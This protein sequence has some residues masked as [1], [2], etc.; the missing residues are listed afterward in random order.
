MPARPGGATWQ[1]LKAAGWY[2]LFALIWIFATDRLLGIVAADQA[3]YADFQTYKGVAF[4]VVTALLMFLLVRGPLAKAMEAGN[5]ARMAAEAMRYSEARFRGIYERALA[6]ILIVS[7]DGRIERCNPAA[8][9]MLGY[10]E[11]ELKGRHFTDIIHPEDR[12]SD[13]DKGR[14]LRAGELTSFEVES[15]YLRKD[16]VAVWVR[17]IVS[18]LPESDSASPKVFA[19]ALDLTESRAAIRA[20]RESEQRLNHVMAATGEGI[21]DWRIATGEVTHNAQWCRL[22]GLSEDFL[23]HQVAF[24]S[25]LVHPDDHERVQAAIDRCLRGEEAYLSEHRMRRTD[26]SYIWVADRGDIVERDER[27]NA[28]RMVGSLTEITEQKEA[29]QEAE[30]Q[31]LLFRSVFE[32]SPDAMILTDTGGRVTD[33]NPAFTRI[34]GYE[35]GELR[36][37]DTRPL[38]ASEQDW[39][40]TKSSISAGRTNLPPQEGVRKNGEEFPCQVTSAEMLDASGRSAGYITIARD[41]SEERKREL[42]LREK[43]RLESL[44][45][46]TG[47]VAHDFNN[48]LTI[49]SG[50]LQLLEMDVVEESLRQ[51]VVSA[52]RAVEMGARLN[53]RLITFARQ[54]RLSSVPVDLNALVSSMLELIRRSVGEDVTVMTSLTAE[55]TIVS[56]DVSELENAI[57]NLALNARDA[58][59]AG[60]ALLIETAPIE[61]DADEALRVDVS[62]GRYVRMSVAD[63][64]VG[65]SSE[66]LGR[67]FEPFFTTK[68][69]GKG[70]GLGLTSLHGFVRQSAGHVSIY[71]EPGK[72]TTVDICLPLIDT[73]PSRIADRAPARERPRGNGERILLVEDNPD[74]RAITAERLR[75]LGYQVVEADNGVSALAVA[76]SGEQID[77]LFSDVVMPGGIGGFDLARRFRKLWPSAGILLTSGFPDAFLRKDAQEPSTIRILRKPYA[78]D[79]LARSI[80]GALDEVRPPAVAS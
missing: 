26:G 33:A 6:A 24:F 14:R 41:V 38:F 43:Q 55:Q 44:G 22:L 2:L 29:R 71:S 68:E 36:G 23:Q 27:G 70:S 73:E 34:F 10:E 5:E 37:R 53:Q 79:E 49:I 18:T 63:T 67:A 25:G 13:G 74:V 17:K 32:Y 62:P 46:L 76:E 8:C 1:A 69:P 7:W 50:N 51:R 9:R 45:R 28:L 52:L 61:I 60:G 66:V 16:G 59:P 30:R 11:C 15:R 21:W 4:V 12:A 40:A 77:A 35:R 78:Q 20:V 75:Q 56:I 48:L 57:L 19:L 72:G 58:M 47:G 42:A 3:T 65:M 39:I 64:G 31:Q 80:A 54:R